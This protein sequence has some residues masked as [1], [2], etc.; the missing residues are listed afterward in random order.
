MRVAVAITGAS[1]I[2]LALRTIDVL[3]NMKI[4]VEVALSKDAIEVS[5]IEPCFVDP[6][7]SC[8]IVDEIRKRGLSPQ[9]SMTSHLASSSRVPDAVVVVPCSMKT[10]GMIAHGIG[11]TLPS[12]LALNAIR[13]GKKTVLVPRESPV[14]P[15][16]LENMLKLSKIGVHIV[17]PTLAFYIKP[18]SISDIIDFIVGKILDVLGID[19]NLYQ[20]YYPH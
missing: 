20:R 3:L 12:R 6:P 10:L 17:L 7:I 8:N 4:N 9:I 14:G 16:E 1:G 5:K 11:S 13:M 18:K 19:H 2:P 15:L